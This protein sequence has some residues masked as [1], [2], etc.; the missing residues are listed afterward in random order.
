MIDSIEIRKSGRRNN[1]MS[2]P[3]K[4]MR[5]L[6]NNVGKNGPVTALVVWFKTSPNKFGQGILLMPPMVAVSS[7]QIYP[8]LR[9]IRRKAI[10]TNKKRT[11]HWAFIKTLIF[12]ANVITI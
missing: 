1:K 8:D 10:N 12:F 6:D 4:L 11:N 2:G 5:I 7:N 3:K 9:F